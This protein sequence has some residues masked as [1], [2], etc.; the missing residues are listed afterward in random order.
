MNLRSR[1]TTSGAN[2]PRTKRNEQ[3]ATAGPSN[4][5]SASNTIQQ[6]PEN[7]DDEES[8][9]EE[10]H[11]SISTERDE[12][13]LEPQGGNLAQL[14]AENQSLN[15]ELVAIRLQ[16]KLAKKRQ[17][18][19][20]IRQELEEYQQPPEED[21]RTP[22]RSSAVP[23]PAPPDPREVNFPIKGAALQSQLPK[24][25]P[26]TKFAGKG[27]HEWDKW[28]KECEKFFIRVP[29]AF[30]TEAQ[31]TEFAYEHLGDTQQERWDNVKAAWPVA[32]Q[33]WERMKEYMLLSLGTEQERK[34]S[35]FARIK[36][37]TQGNRTPSDLLQYLRV[38][39]RELGMQDEEIQI[40]EFKAAL[41]DEIQKRLFYVPG[42]EYHSLSKMELDAEETYRDIKR[43]SSK[44]AQKQTPSET[45]NSRKRSWSA[46]NNPR[47]HQ[48]RQQQSGP[49]SSK[50]DRSKEDRSNPNKEGKPKSDRPGPKCYNCNKIGH[51][52]KNC[53]APKKETEKAN[54]T[55]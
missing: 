21:E 8:E 18:L 16:L 17:M 49:S 7:P 9:A 34:A 5:Q 38:Q 37:A 25:Q 6:D 3:N 32:E 15:D 53:R 23:T 24:P 48:N 11:E 42:V 54:P 46:A 52:A 13:D 51:I 43:E 27:R 35:A 4:S 29:H 22:A 28:K 12:D 10:Q 33:T 44:S 55:T 2:R 31:R 40:L 41:S 26:P 47:T 45:K 36:R 50:E 20:R 1:D 39:W 19:A 14:E 30:E